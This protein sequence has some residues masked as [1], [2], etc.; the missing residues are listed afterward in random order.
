MY[1]FSLSNPEKYQVM[2]K[3][4]HVLMSSLVLPS[5][6]TFL[7]PPETQEDSIKK[8]ICYGLS[9]A[10]E[11][12]AERFYQAAVQLMPQPSSTKTNQICDRAQLVQSLTSSLTTCS[13]EEMTD[14]PPKLQ[15]GIHRKS[16]VEEAGALTSSG[17]FPLPLEESIEDEKSLQVLQVSYG[18]VSEDEGLED[19]DIDGKVPFK[20]RYKRKDRKSTLQDSMKSDWRGLSGSGSV[21]L[22]KEPAKRSESL[23]EIRISYPTSV[24]HTAHINT[25]TPVH[26]LKQ[27]V[28]TGKSLY[29]VVD[30][31]N[32]EPNNKRHTKLHRTPSAP[33]RIRHHSLPLKPLH[34]PTILVTPAESPK[35]KYPPINNLPSPPPCVTDF[36]ELLKQLKVAENN[37]KDELTNSL[38][39]WQHSF[40]SAVANLI[41]KKLHDEVLCSK[42]LSLTQS[43]REETSEKPTSRTTSVII[44]DHGIVCL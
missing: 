36:Q 8:E 44:H 29:T 10:H 25:H 19:V 26:A 13:P 7:T 32:K 42:L 22:E 41:R 34:R 38:E 11:K 3:H 23:E 15:S 6:N 14:F 24:K 4:F 1:E 40:H 27:V 43:G 28:N 39:A 12:V 30:N 35:R 17:R 16:M 20:M 9:F 37:D 18:T 2:D 21:F 31:E 33:T 5:S